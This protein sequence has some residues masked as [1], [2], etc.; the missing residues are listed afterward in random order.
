MELVSNHCM[1]YRELYDDHTGN[2]VSRISISAPVCVTSQEWSAQVSVVGPQESRFEVLGFDS[3]QVM[4]IAFEAVRIF[5]S[6]NLKG[7]HWT[8]GEKGDN[9]F[10]MIVPRCFGLTHSLV[11]EK[12]LDDAV[13][14]VAAELQMK[15]QTGPMK[16]NAK[17][18]RRPRV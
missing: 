1:I 5:L 16:R 8:G 10:N 12:M 17:V 3:V 2:L 4:F 18:G 13:Q 6:K 9:G 14:R 11:F 15:N 7:V